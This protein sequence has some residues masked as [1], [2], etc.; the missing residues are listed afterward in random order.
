MTI[1]LNKPHGTQSI[2]YSYSMDGTTV[3]LRTER[4]PTLSEEVGAIPSSK[5]KGVSRLDRKWWT[6]DDVAEYLGTTRRATQQFM[7]KY[8]VRRSKA[9]KRLTCR[10]WVDSALNRKAKQTPKG[11]KKDIQYV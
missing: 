2:S 8:Q 4:P 3:D 7:W 10:D 1:N 9:N 6:V 11:K 5:A